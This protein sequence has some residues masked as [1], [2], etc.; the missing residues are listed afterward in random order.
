M[1]VAATRD[2]ATQF[3]QVPVTTNPAGADVILKGAYIGSTP[4]TL[5][6]TLDEHDIAIEMQGYESWH[7][8]IKVQPGLRIDVSL[9]AKRP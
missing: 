3:V 2:R 1:Q 8:R 5:Q 4:T 9:L 7:R 6:L